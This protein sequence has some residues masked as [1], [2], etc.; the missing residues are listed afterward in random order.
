MTSTLSETIAIAAAF[1]KL[2]IIGVLLVAVVLAALAAWYFR[3]DAIAAHQLREQQIQ[4]ARVESATALKQLDEV[5]DRLRDDVST[6]KQ[7]L[8]IVRAAADNAG[9]KYDLRGIGDVDAMLR[10]ER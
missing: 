5:V 2:G 8:T 4:A 7:M 9:V 10:R 1:E 6:L 3:K